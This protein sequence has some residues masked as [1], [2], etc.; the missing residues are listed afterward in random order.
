MRFSDNLPKGCDQGS[1]IRESHAAAVSAGSRDARLNIRL[2]ELAPVAPRAKHSHAL[3]SKPLGTNAEKVATGK[4]RLPLTEALP[5]F[6]R[7]AIYMMQ[8]S[9]VADSEI[10][11]R[12]LALSIV[13]GTT[14][15]K[16]NELFV[17]RRWDLDADN[18]VFCLAVRTTKFCRLWHEASIAPVM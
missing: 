8:R 9:P 5:Q 13:K 3:Y 18:L 17:A 11:E 4:T 12:E 16:A 7:P 10:L 15:T 1:I 2:H 14:A 6:R